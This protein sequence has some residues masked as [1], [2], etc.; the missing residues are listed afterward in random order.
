MTLT[1]PAK[2]DQGGHEQVNLRDKHCPGPKNNKFTE[3]TSSEKGHQKKIMF[4]QGVTA[5]IRLDE[6]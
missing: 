2:G 4:P 6:G 3:L 1:S 5:A